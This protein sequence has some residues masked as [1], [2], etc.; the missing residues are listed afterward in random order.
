MWETAAM[1]SFEVDDGT[2]DFVSTTYLTVDHV[3]SLH[4]MLVEH[5]AV[6]T[7]PIDPPGIKNE[8]LLASAVTRPQTSLGREEKYKTLE[9]KAAAF[10]HS[11]VKI[12]HFTME[13]SGRRSYHSS[14]SLTKTTDE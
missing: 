1:P 4:K 8:G 3:V 11:L 14:H 12:I 2:L 9:T 7:D 10:F 5:F 6:T 13:T